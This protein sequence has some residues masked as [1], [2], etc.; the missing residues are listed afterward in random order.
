LRIGQPD[1]EKLLRAD[2]AIAVGL[3]KGLAAIV[4]DLAPAEPPKGSPRR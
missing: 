2:P 4:R 1:F 3:A